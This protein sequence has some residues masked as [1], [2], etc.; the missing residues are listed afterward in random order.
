M[1]RWVDS[2]ARRLPALEAGCATTAGQA[3]RPADRPRRRGGSR[4]EAGRL[5]RGLVGGREPNDEVEVDR[6]ISPDPASGET[7]AKGDTITV[8][9]SNGA[10]EVNVP[11]LIGQTRA[12]AAAT[13]VAAGLVL[14][15][16]SEEPSDRPGGAAP[17][18]APRAGGGGREGGQ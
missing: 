18:P 3:P 7:V 14:G 1:L 6:V 10:E 4:G 16:V 2:A 11:V 12:E 15:A 13:L 5:D 17:P 9:V 8:V